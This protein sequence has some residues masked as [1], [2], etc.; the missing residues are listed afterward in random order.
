MSEY[1]IDPGFVLMF[2]CF[3]IESTNGKG[4]VV[5][6][7]EGSNI[8]LLVLT[9]ADVA[10][11]FCQA[12]GYSGNRRIRF[13][14]AADLLAYLEILPPQITQVA[15]DSVKARQPVERLR[16]NLMERLVGLR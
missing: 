3:V 4:G 9:D 14:G 16:Q 7:T 13:D 10:D 8:A 15:Y 6:D 2:P 12:H 11:R 5:M 1:P